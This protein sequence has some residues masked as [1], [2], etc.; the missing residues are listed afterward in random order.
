MNAQHFCSYCF[1]TSYCWKSLCVSAIGSYIGM[2][3]FVG[4]LRSAWGSVG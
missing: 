2:G 4:A 3:S 1:S